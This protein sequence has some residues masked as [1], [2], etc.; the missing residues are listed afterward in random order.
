MIII[1]MFILQFNYLFAN[2]EIT[3]GLNDGKCAIKVNLRM[4]WEDA[5]NY[6]ASRQGRLITP[7][8]LGH[9]F[10]HHHL[11]MDLGNNF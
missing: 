4:N 9:S 3:M 2:P 7:F 8:L 11:F 10:L 5:D 1:F 6:C